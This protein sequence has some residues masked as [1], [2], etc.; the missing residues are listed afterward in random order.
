MTLWALNNL[1]SAKDV[2][3]T[4]KLAVLCLRVY[5]EYEMR[6]RGVRPVAIRLPVIH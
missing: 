3:T 2:Y 6:L 1:R 5:V 4:H